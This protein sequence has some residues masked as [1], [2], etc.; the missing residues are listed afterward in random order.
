MHIFQ[1]CGLWLAEGD[2]AERKK[3][4]S[5]FSVLFNI[6]LPFY[7]KMM[8]LLGLFSIFWPISSIFH[9]D[10]LYSFLDVMLANA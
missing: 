8:L 4:C 2:K 1:K 9:Y 3:G 5:D 7:G 10:V 6:S